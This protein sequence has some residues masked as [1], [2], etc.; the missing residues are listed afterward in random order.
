TAAAEGAATAT[1]SSL[2]KLS[3]RR[4]ASASRFFWLVPCSLLDLSDLMI[5]GRTMSMPGRSD[6]RRRTDRRKKNTGPPGG[7]ER[8]Q[9]DRRRSSGRFVQD[10]IE[11]RR[12]ARHHIENGAVTESY[13][14]EPATVIAI[15]NEALATEIVCV[16]RYRRHYFM[17]TGIHAQT[18]ADEFL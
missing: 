13:A 18:V 15:L 6:E 16:L 3:S 7:K 4:E 14:I 5:E 8:R 12:R 1:R 2:S 10:V 17:A 9:G 11:L